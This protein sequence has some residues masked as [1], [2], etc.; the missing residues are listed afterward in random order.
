M[1]Q[2][3]GSISPIAVGL[4][5][6]PDRIAVES[7]RIAKI[8]VGGP[9]LPEGGELILQFDNGG[10]L[11]LNLPPTPT[12]L[13]TEFRHLTTLD[14]SESV[15]VLLVKKLDTAGTRAIVGAA[16]VDFVVRPSP[17][18]FEDPLLILVLGWSLGIVSSKIAQVGE[19]ERR[20]AELIA[21]WRDLVE[22]MTRDLQDQLSGRQPSGE[23]STW[24]RQ[25]RAL[26]GNKALRTK[27]RREIESACN[28]LQAIQ[29]RVSDCNVRKEM[30]EEMRSAFQREIQTVRNGAGV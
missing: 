14:A 25:A 22:S 1:T 15:N 19:S 29:K 7:P 2:D 27:Q 30:N 28:R 10:S 26:I 21:Q 8:R 9:I 5:V 17:D 20:R 4:V 6:S 3:S 24:I 11:T 16:K 18:V 13:F 12:P 23:S